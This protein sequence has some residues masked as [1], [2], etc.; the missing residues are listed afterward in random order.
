MMTLS[1]LPEICFLF[2]SPTCIN[3]APPWKS[4][5]LLEPEESFLFVTLQNFGGFDLDPIQVSV[6]PKRSVPIWAFG[7][8][9]PLPFLTVVR[10]IWASMAL[11]AHLR[12][13]ITVF[14]FYFL[15]LI[16]T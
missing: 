8:L 4:Q 15:W 9:G 13:L 6:G 16:W 12:L 2:G 7:L 1:S 3:G 5:W 11:K 14:Y 10:P